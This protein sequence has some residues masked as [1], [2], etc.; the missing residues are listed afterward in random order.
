M[1]VAAGLVLLGGCDR[2]LAEGHYRWEGIHGFA[3]WPEDQPEL[4]SQA[5]E[6]KR[7]Y[8]SWRGDPGETAERFVTEMLDWREPPDLSEH[9]VPEGAPRTAFSMTDGSM[10]RSAL[11]VVVHLRQLR[12][13]W[14]VARVIPRE[15]DAGG[16][17]EWVESTEGYALHATW[18][19]E[20]PINLEV[21]W[22]SEMH[23][24][25]MASGDTAEFEPPDPTMPGHY[26][27][28]Y[29]E[30]SDLTFGQPLSPPPRFP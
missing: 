24:V 7:V 21:G 22:G 11:G 3:I 17:L 25:V 23:R 8:E 19:G 26:I 15:G 4:A 1:L 10:S 16:Q 2:P 30:P 9:E 14:F 6:I 5:C 18:E 27:W 29:D 13:C 12:G 28:Y 20:R